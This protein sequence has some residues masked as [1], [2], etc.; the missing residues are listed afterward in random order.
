MGFFAP[1]NVETPPAMWGVLWAGGVNSTANPTYTAKEL[2]FQM[3]DSRAK[4]IVT[5][6]PLLPLALE[7]AKKVGIPEDRILLIGEKEPSGKFKHY[8]EVCNTSYLSFPARTKVDPR[9]DLA[10]L[11]YSSGTTGLP[12]GVMLTHRNL[13]A[14][15]CQSSGAE[16]LNGISNSGGPD[17]QGDR[18]LAVL[19]FFHVYGLTNILHANIYC[20]FQAV[21]MPKFELEQA[22]AL[23]QK[24]HITFAYVPPPIILGLGKHPAVSKYD[25]SSLKWLNSG[26]APLSKELVD[27][28]WER[29]RI[30]VKQGYG[31]SECAPVTHMQSVAEWAKYIGSIGKLV[32]H[33]ESKIV[34]PDTGDE[35]TKPGEAGEIWV[36]GPNVFPGYIN[37]PELNKDNITDDGFFKTGDIGYVDDKGNF[38]ITDRLKELIKYSKPI[39]PLLL[40]ASHS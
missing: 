34:D 40:P 20:G 2:T 39:Q 13:V 4:G 36:R 38:Y 10:Y 22:C 28:L 30:P 17:G 33:V 3:R 16:R 27:V 24:Y 18:Q 15:I 6:K 12:K 25:L 21:V 35:M 8:T 19:P 26:A 5:I 37:R 29:L 31:L 23:I 32:S 7:A 9:K 14:N 11:V 1:N